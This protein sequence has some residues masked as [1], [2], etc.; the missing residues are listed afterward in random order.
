MQIQKPRLFQV[1]KYVLGCEPSS[2]AFIGT[3]GLFWP[4]EVCCCLSV[5]EVLTSLSCLSLVFTLLG[6]V[7]NGRAHDDDG[8]VFDTG[9]G[10][11][12]R[13]TL[14]GGTSTMLK[15]R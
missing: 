5:S 14:L 2:H 13:P 15:E 4:D 9:G 11:R 10:G 6:A 12:G 3:D 7:G 8:S 1:I